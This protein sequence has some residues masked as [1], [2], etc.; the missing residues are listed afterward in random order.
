MFKSTKDLPKIPMTW[1][2]S[3]ATK[4]GGWRANRPIID[5]GQCIKCHICWKF[6]PD[7]AIFIDSD[8]EG[9]PEIDLEHCKGCGIC[10]F[11]CPKECITMEREESQ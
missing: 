1:Q 2:P 4:T 3:S 7:V 10:A 9:Y 8:P 11:E 6:C 5:K